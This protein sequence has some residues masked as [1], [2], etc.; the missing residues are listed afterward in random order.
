MEEVEDDG[1]DGMDCGMH[2]LSSEIWALPELLQ[3]SISAHSLGEVSA[4]ALPSF[5]PGTLGPFCASSEKIKFP[6]DG[7]EG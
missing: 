1:N 3:S 4:A 6:T 5:L 7:A 2:S